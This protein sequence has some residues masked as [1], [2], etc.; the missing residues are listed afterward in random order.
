MNNQCFELTPLSRWYGQRHIV[1]LSRWNTYAPLMA[2]VQS[3]LPG[4]TPPRHSSL[5][6][7]FSICF[8]L[9]RGQNHEKAYQKLVVTTSRKTTSKSLSWSEPRERGSQGI[10]S[11]TE[12]Q[13]KCQYKLPGTY[14]NK[15]GVTASKSCP[16][17]R[18]PRRSTSSAH[19][20]RRNPQ[21]T[22]SPHLESL[23]HKRT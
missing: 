15:N 6:S 11:V 18:S 3:H 12:W 23:L 4:L 16:T 10:G 14:A 22:S 2:K 17:P 8:K 19:V 5:P 7:K 21:K 9:T 1:S 13:N 20:L